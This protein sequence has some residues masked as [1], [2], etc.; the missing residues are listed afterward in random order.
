MLITEKE[1]NYT[2]L[3]EKDSYIF[4]SLDKYSRRVCVDHAVIIYCSCNLT[5]GIIL[6]YNE[7][8]Y[9]MLFSCS[10]CFE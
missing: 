7:Y 6:I 5:Y 10:S 8:T 3:I 1:N 4:R 2:T 9:Y